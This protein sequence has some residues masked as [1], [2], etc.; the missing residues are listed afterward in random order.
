MKE[1]NAKRFYVI[2]TDYDDQCAFTNFNLKGKD[3]CNDMN[4][5]T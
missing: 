1:E 3:Q 4:D 5:V 2:A